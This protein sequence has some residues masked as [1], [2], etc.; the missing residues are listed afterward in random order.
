MATNDK[1]LNAFK[2]EEPNAFY[3]YKTVYPPKYLEPEWNMVFPT[4]NSALKGIHDKEKY[5]DMEGFRISKR[6]IG[7]DKYIDI[8]ATLDGKV[9]NYRTNE[10]AQADYCA[11][12]GFQGT[13][14]EIPTPF[15]KGDILFGANPHTFR[16]GEFGHEPFV[17]TSICYWDNEKIQERLRKHGD[18]NDMTAYGYWVD[19]DGQVYGECMHSYQ[20]LEY[21]R[22]KL[23]G[24]SRILT[25]I[26]NHTKGEIDCE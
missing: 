20:N 5:D 17:L 25:A 12:D 7:K 23:T 4:F 22:G 3:L 11:E 9:M 16:D 8:W 21:Y 1:I 2:E 19:E 24:V 13:W 26:S 15:K 18:S 14:I 6:W 10:F